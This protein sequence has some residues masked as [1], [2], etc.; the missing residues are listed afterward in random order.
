MFELMQKWFSKRDSQLY[1]TLIIVLAILWLVRSFLP[2]MLL[3]AIFA[4]FGLH[5][6]KWIAKK[7]PIPYGTAV[8]LFYVVVV[9]IVVGAISFIAP[10]LMTEGMGLYDK[11]LHGLNSYPQLDQWVSKYDKQFNVL[12]RL[13]KNWQD[14]L[15]GGLTVATSVIDILIRIALA[16]FL[17]LIFSL[18]YPSLTKFGDRFKQSSFPKFFSY[19]HEIGAKFITILGKTIE[20]QL[21]IDII[22]TIIMVIGLT[23][24]G[25]PSPAVLGMIVFIFGLVPVAG[26]L[27]SSVPL[28]LIA[29]S[30]GSYQRVVTLVILIILIHMLESYFLN[31]RLM[32]S[33]A[34]MPI[35]LTFVTLLVAE[36]FLGAWGLILGVPMVSYLLDIFHVNNFAGSMKNR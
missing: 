22:N 1:V 15:K 11:I 20:V 6:S 9:G 34:H 26:M 36:H 35:F 17:S 23:I 28:L 5:A 27:I 10:M 29:L 19:V 13:S 7:T 32:S 4:Y 30:T 24:M 18:T 33:R 25:M 8:I 12:D 3:T 21:I 14:V 2:T 16:L 31:P